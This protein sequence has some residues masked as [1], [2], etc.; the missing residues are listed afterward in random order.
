MRLK[1]IQVHGFKTFANRTDF[2]FHEGITAIVGPNG[3]GKSN[4]A[5]AIRWALGEQSPTN[6]RT[7]KTED[8]IFTGSATRA[9]MGM[10]EVALTLENPL[11]LGDTAPLNGDS[12]GTDDLD[13]GEARPR[14]S[15]VQEILHARPSEVTVLRRAYR[16]GENEYLINRQRVR[17]RDVQELLQRWGLARLTYAVIGQ[18]LIDQALSLRAEERRALF[19][20]AAGIGLYQVKKAN[21]LDKL[22]ETRQNLIRVNDIIN[23]IAPRLPSLA[24]QADRAGKYESVATALNDKL[25]QWYAYQWAHAQEGFLAAEAQETTARE[26]LNAR[27]AAMH[28]LAARLGDARKAAQVLRARLAEHRQ[29]RQ[30]SENQVAT[31]ERELAVLDERARFAATRHS[32]AERD[33]V[34]ATSAAQQASAVLDSFRAAPPPE[35]DAASEP[36]PELESVTL[37]F[38]PPLPPTFDDDSVQAEEDRAETERLDA[39]A[40]AADAN[41]EARL[42]EVD[43]S[44]A[45]AGTEH[46]AALQALT[47]AAETAQLAHRA[48]AE[49]ITAELQSARARIEDERA[50]ALAR[51]RLAQARVVEFGLNGDHAAPGTLSAGHAA[52]ASPAPDLASL[53]IALQD[54]LPLYESALASVAALAAQA[55]D[56]ARRERELRERERALERARAELNSAQAALVV[57]ERDVEA[58]RQQQVSALQEHERAGRARAQDDERAAGALAREQ[59][60]AREQLARAREQIARERE[61]IALDHAALVRERARLAEARARERQRERDRAAQEQQRLATQA[62]RERERRAQERSRERE[63]LRLAHAQEDERLQRAHAN[64]EQ[65]Q[66]ARAARVQS[67]AAE[68]A[69]ATAAR[70]AARTRAESLR[71]ALAD[72][73]ATAFPDEAALAESERLQNELEEREGQLRHDLTAAEELYNRDVL[74]AERRRAEIAR[75]EQEIEDDLGPVELDSAAP[76]QL[77]LRL[78]LHDRAAAPSTNPADDVLA[79]RPDDER[80]DTA[81]EPPAQELVTLPDV[82]FLPDNFDKEIRRLKNQMRYI[83]NVNPNA[84]QEY[85]QLKERHAFLTE[86]AADLTGALEKLQQATQELDALMKQKFQETFQSINVEFRKYFALLFGGGT[87]RLELTDPDDLIHS[88]IEITARPPGKRAAQLV[89]LSGGERALTAAALV[90]AI[91]KVSPTPFCVMDEVDA[92]LDEANVGRFRDALAE[93]SQATQFIVITH[94]RVTMEGARA[95][96]GVSMGE[97]GVSQVLSLKLEQ[98]APAA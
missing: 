89:L 10:A 34:A 11:A 76:R 58:A 83:G 20:E 69:A 78:I 88:G 71:A 81:L 9:R 96:Y 33:L 85:A 62:Q 3:C 79:D 41:Q 26:T 39:A 53:L 94:N 14:A 1:H 35:L 48:Q 60:R 82:A 54:H 86:Q 52:A 31:A 2:L 13:S 22:E 38:A 12:P 5:D 70:D 66:L 87:A 64:A 92:A 19:E 91:L 95:I 63:R 15:I 43:R 68:L 90:F 36:E 55:N 84:P 77:R 21:A 67:L 23:E 6:L 4:I 65:E 98:A 16:S 56:L 17:L 73:Q 42:Q 47:R 46:A 57:A 74:E 80:A 28:E 51:R 30:Q 18:G 25:K 37:A 75:L 24:R 40:R 93:L 27:R 97:D 44:L 8:L 45:Q 32:E 61:R 29:V 49:Q 59:E 7:K 72:V 50:R